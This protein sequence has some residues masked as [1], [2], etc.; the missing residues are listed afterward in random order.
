MQQ[1]KPCKSCGQILPLGSFHNTSGNLDGKRN[2]CKSCTSKR[3]AE[4][5]AKDAEAM[6]AKSRQFYWDNRESELAR[7]KADREKDP[8]AHAEKR[9]Q[10]RL[11]NL[12][13]YKTIE[14]NQ[15]IKHR[16]R[17]LARQRERSKE[18]VENNLRKNNRRR[19]R[20]AQ[21]I[22]YFVSIKEVKKLKDSPCFTCGEKGSIEIDHII[23]L[24]RGG[25]NGIGNY[26]A[27]C[28]T[29]NAS[30][31]NKTFMEWRLYR[32][33]VGDPLPMDRK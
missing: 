4:R 22:S 26:M 29:C 6:R 33:K 2:V 9:R 1:S 17:R 12:D 21:A 27:L 32:I 3:D 28:E 16:E 25:V 19:A 23:A 18:T 13:A 8:V 10:R 30:K 7:M 5:Y 14:Y 24:T 20:I 11:K 15:R 31:Y